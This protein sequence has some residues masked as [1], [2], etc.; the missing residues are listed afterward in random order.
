LAN[1]NLKDLQELEAGETGDALSKLKDIAD[2][3]NPMAK[4]ALSLYNR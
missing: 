4:A 1:R 3:G 2:E